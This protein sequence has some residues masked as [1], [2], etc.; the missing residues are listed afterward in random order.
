MWKVN[1]LCW[2]SYVF[3]RKTQCRR[4]VVTQQKSREDNK[5]IKTVSFVTAIPFTVN[6]HSIQHFLQYIEANMH[7]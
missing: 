3:D 5:E 2:D 7:K 1:S 4:V 6:D